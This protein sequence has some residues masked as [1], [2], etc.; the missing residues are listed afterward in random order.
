RRAASAAC[1][2]FL[3]ATSRRASG[4]PLLRPMK[5][6]RSISPQS[7]ALR[8]SARRSTGLPSASSQRAFLQPARISTSASCSSTRAM[9]SGCRIGAIGDADLAFDHRDPVERLAPMLIGQLEMTEALTRKIEGAVNAPQL[10][11]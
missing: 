8:N 7:D 3:T 11:P 6:G 9:R 2:D 5:I 10:V 4:L 1:P